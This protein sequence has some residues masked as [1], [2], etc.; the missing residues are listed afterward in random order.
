MIRHP[1]T[2]DYADELVNIEMSR[3]LRWI[4]TL[5]DAGEID[6]EQADKLRRLPEPTE[7]RQAA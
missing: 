2:P 7:E 3:R 6:E 4:L 5:I 1:L